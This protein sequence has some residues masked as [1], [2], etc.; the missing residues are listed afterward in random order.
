[1]K[2]A[3]LILSISFLC[4]YL[5][6]QPAAFTWA[7][8][9]DNTFKYIDVTKAKDQRE[10]G[11]CH[12]F[13]SV[14]AVEAMAHIYYNYSA[15][16]GQDLDLSE[17]NLY[18]E[19]DCGLGCSEGEGGAIDVVN[20]LNEIK[21]VGIV[22]EESFQYPIYPNDPC[23]DDCEN[24]SDPYTLVK[25]PAYETITSSIRNNTDLKE[26]IMD[27][28]PIIATITGEDNGT[29]VG[30]ALH[31]TDEDCDAA[32][33][34][35]II[36][37][38]SSPEFMWHIKDSWPDS[39]YV[40]YRKLNIFNYTPWFYRVVPKTST[41]SIKCQGNDC[42]IFTRGMSINYDK[43]NDGFYNWGIDTE[44]RPGG[45]PGSDKMDFDD[46]DPNK[47]FRV[48]Y[49]TGETA[50]SITRYPDSDYICASGATYTLNN[51]PQNFNVKWEVTPAN[52]FN[53]PSGEDDS[54]EISPVA[55][56]IGKVGELTFTISHNGDVE[57]KEEFII[58]GPLESQVSVTVEDEYGGS[59]PK[60]GSTYY[61]CP[62]TKYY[63]YYNNSDN[64]CSTST[65]D[66]E[67]HVPSGWYRYWD[68]GNCMAFNTQN[69]PD[70]Q[71]DIYAKT[72]FC[73]PSTFVKVFTQYFGEDDCEEYF[74]AF[75]NPTDHYVEIDVKKE[76]FAAEN[77][78]LNAECI[79]TM[80][81]KTGLV[82]YK[83]EFKG[84]PYRIDTSNLPEGLY[85]VNL[86]YNGKMSSIRLVVEH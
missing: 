47:I 5:S 38:K 31:S 70:A 23:R 36:G 76:K 43:D 21:Y 45:W 32:H 1:M 18:N 75:P 42:S 13:A 78:S 81:D 19:D 46:R 8:R 33:S 6:A 66:R 20:S 15:N 85:F 28:G 65:F 54:A 74:R 77:I 48:G 14:A 72:S 50:P 22:D 52:Y 4:L 24:I 79:L 60:Y 12:I 16:A 80:L 17:S 64:N 86:L 82:K 2:K 53:S 69:D 57:Y 71:L 39:A 9:H 44:D 68:N 40:N 83:D 67:N 37:W 27:Y 49:N 7:S 61:L 34:I 59:P 11:P 58:N 29:Q 10:Q 63:V 30:C 3:I 56:N 73:S 25:I 55:G 26:A 62:N 51:L 84:F 41:D 35:L